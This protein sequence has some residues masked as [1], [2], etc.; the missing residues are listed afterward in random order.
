VSEGIACPLTRNGD[1]LI[2]LRGF[3]QLLSPSDG[4]FHL[5]RGLVPLRCP[6]RQVGAA[7][8]DDRRHKS[9]TGQ[10]DRARGDGTREKVKNTEALRSEVLV[11]AEKIREHRRQLEEEIPVSQPPGK[12]RVCGQRSKCRQSRA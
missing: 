9:R 12:C 5:I 10:L 1:Q 3:G 6:S 2:R 11:V 7:K 8:A 4:L